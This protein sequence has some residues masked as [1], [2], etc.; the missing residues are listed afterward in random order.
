MR[1]LVKVP[2]RYRPLLGQIFAD[3]ADAVRAIE[4]GPGSVCLEVE[5][6]RGETLCWHYLGD[7]K[8]EICEGAP[9]DKGQPLLHVK[10]TAEQLRSAMESKKSIREVA[11]ATNVQVKG[12]IDFAFRVLAAAEKV[13]SHNL[14]KEC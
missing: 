5:F 2:E 8:R 14:R 9:G 3:Y 12:D 4:H 7:G 13:R 1:E 10:V 11:F 6:D